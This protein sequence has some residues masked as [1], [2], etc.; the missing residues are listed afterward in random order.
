MRSLL[1]N[2]SLGS[3]AIRLYSYYL[4]KLFPVFR[5]DGMKYFDPW[6]FTGHWRK[7]GGGWRNWIKN[8]TYSLTHSCL[9]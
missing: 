5:L 3:Y 2:F 6:F 1:E 8:K 9:L 7:L 4:S